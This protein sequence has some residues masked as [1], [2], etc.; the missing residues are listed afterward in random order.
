[1]K[2]LIG[3]A[4]AG[5]MAGMLVVGCDLLSNPVDDDTCEIKLTTFSSITAD[6]YT[7]LEA[8]IDANVEITAVT[9]TV[10]KDGE[11]VD[12]D[13]IDIQ[14]EALP[15]GEKKIDIEEN[16]EM[17]IMINVADDA[18][19]GEYV[20]TLS[21]TA[22]SAEASKSNTFT[23]SDGRDCSATALTEKS[24]MIANI[25]GP[26]TGAFNLVDGK[27]VS[28]SAA[29]TTKDLMDLS[30]VGE[31]FAGELGSGNGAKFATASASD[32][33]NATDVS[34]PALAADAEMD[35]VDVSTV[36]TVFVVKLGNSR[37][38]AIV[39]ITSYDE[40]AGASTGENKGEVEFVYK[41]TD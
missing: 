39:K 38:Y 6:S 17:E 40:D 34:V 37:G 22:G 11:A 20:L 8:T 7:Y 24:G 1:M 10:T 25:F 12:D 30:L 28:S 21:A 23:V 32:Y 5:T 15:S 14:K 19:D 29:S 33:T 31:G 9:V 26:D 27:R 41:F 4:V 35:E 36:G 16:G 2:R 13:L 3:L 18:C